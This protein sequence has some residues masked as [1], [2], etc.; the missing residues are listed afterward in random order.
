MG[1]VSRQKGMIERNETAERQRRR[2]SAPIGCGGKPH[3][4]LRGGKIS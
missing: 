1:H 4:E 3:V 2:G